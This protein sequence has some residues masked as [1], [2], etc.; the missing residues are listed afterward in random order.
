MAATHTSFKRLDFWAKLM[1]SQFRVPGTGIRFGLD[2]VIGLIPGGGDFVTFLF[3]AY[4]LNTM[5]KNGAS[6]FVLARM[7]FNIVLDA[8]VGSIPFIGDL[9]DVAFKANQRNMRLM[10]EHYVEGR[11][12]GSALKLI[13][14]L[15]LFLG[16]FIGVMIWLSYRLFVWLFHGMNW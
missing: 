7:V 16:L 2:A 9:F 11:H 10:H 15:L 1:D 8:I 4:L 5:A 6:G 14:P 3:S 13:V 12:Q